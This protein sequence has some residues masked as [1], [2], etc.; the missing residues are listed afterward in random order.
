MEKCDCKIYKWGNRNVVITINLPQ[1][2]FSIKL[3]GFFSPLSWGPY[4]ITFASAVPAHR[5]KI[6]KKVIGTCD[7]KIK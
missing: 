1:S 7:E 4:S 6:P 5:K 3:V 2:H